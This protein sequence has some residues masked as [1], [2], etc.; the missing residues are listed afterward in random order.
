[1]VFTLVMSWLLA[2]TPASTVAPANID[3]LLTATGLPALKTDHPL[4]IRV[5][6][7][8]QLSGYTLK[9]L[10]FDSLPQFPS[11]A[12]LYTP[13]ASNGI[14][15]LVLPGHF[16]DGKSS[17]ES[18][19]I[20]HTLA[21]RGYTVLAVDPPG[22]EQFEHA[23]HQI[24]GEQGAHNRAILASGSLSAL[25]LQLQTALRGVDALLAQ[26]DVQ[27]IAVTGASGGAV[28]GLYTLL[29]DRRLEAGAFA[30]FVPLP[31]EVRASGCPCD[32]IPGW[33]G[34]DPTVLAAIDRPTIWVS[35]V[36][37]P[38][39]EGLPQSARFLVR[40]GEHGFPFEQRK[41][42]VQWLD[43]HFNLPSTP[44]PQD[45]AHVDRNTLVS[46]LPIG[47][48]IAQLA[49]KYGRSET[50]LPKPIETTPYE[51]SCSEPSE[52]TAQ[53]PTVLTLGA[54]PQDMQRLHTSG[55]RTCAVTIPRDQI[56]E[57]AAIIEKRSPTDRPSGA[58]AV[59]ARRTAAVAVYATG[60]YA[61]AA[62]A[63]GVPATL[64]SPTT[65]LTELSEEDPLWVHF[66][67]S[68]WGGL[69]GLYK[70]ALYAGPDR[71]QAVA[72][73]PKRPMAAASSND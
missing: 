60:A 62:V 28:L 27:R 26:S 34:P 69:E 40:K 6:S 9:P 29:A 66:P 19:A 54:T 45:V 2:C 67:G 72:A 37:Q 32:A 44:V 61:V 39:P 58:I 33:P 46:D 68:W 52:N 41:A 73:V 64:R 35:E 23:S 49:Q 12:A 21:M 22:Y 13:Q 11:A 53:P 8:Q 18:Q 70:T 36:E 38:R 5:G 20:S 10:A 55:F 59:A 50:W 31:R 25:G 1:M 24:H 51:L 71:S 63:S 30:S 42:V 16:G 65:A 48:S 47:L 17:P 15:V 57:A 43:K 7:P 56:D 14:G 4:N 3:D